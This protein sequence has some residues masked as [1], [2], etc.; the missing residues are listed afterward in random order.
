MIMPETVLT[1]FPPLH[2]RK[3][4]GLA[5]LI[6]VLTGGVG[7]AVYFKS[8]RDLFPVELAGGLVMAGSLVAGTNPMHVAEFVL[9][10]VGGL[11]G[12]LRARS[13]NRRRAAVPT[14]PAVSAD[15]PADLWLPRPETP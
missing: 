13:S 15:G 11:Y 12:F 4:R 14:T 2:A 3:H 9:P 7:L 1:K 5:V 6:G 8:L 10:V